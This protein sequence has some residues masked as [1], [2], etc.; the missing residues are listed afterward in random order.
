MGEA[1]I[2]SIVL[3]LKKDG[4]YAQGMTRIKSRSYQ[5]GRQDVLNEL[6]SLALNACGILEVYEIIDRLRKD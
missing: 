6:N 1:F 4:T 2:P 5:A 3:E